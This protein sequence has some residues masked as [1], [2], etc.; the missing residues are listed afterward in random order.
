MHNLARPL[1]SGTQDDG[2][3][4]LAGWVHADV[5]EI[6]IQGDEYPVLSYA[7]SLD[8]FVSGPEESL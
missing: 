4:K 3:G 8:L 7:D 6:E 1:S 5:S 2:A